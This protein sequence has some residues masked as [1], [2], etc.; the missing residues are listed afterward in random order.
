METTLL[1]PSRRQVKAPHSTNTI[2]YFSRKVFPCENY[3]IKVEEVTVIPD[4]QISSRKKQ[5]HEI[6]RKHNT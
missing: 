4:V 1:S 2:K 3:S 5:K 6:A